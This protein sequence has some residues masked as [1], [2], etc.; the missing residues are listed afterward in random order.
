MPSNRRRAIAIAAGVLFAAGCTFDY[1][2][3]TDAAAPRRPNIEAFN[4][5]LV[6]ERAGRLEISVRRLATFRDERLQELDGLTV[7]EYGP[8]GKLRLEGS[9]DAAR[10]YLE[11]DNVELI[12]SIVLR[13]FEEDA[14]LR[15]E[16]LFWDDEHRVLSSGDAPAVELLHGDDSW[17]RG[18]SLHLDARRN[19]AVISGAVRGR[20]EVE[21]T[22]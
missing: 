18:S 5:D 11:S 12:G 17:V 6:I 2:V 21:V 1:G 8:D 4:A 14:E 10:I 15:S 20:Y 16:F 3:D 9:A 19:R 22:E 13:S 7:R